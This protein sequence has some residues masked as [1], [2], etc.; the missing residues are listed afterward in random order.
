[1][2]AYRDAA[3]PQ[4]VEEMADQA[5]SLAAHVA[6]LALAHEALVPAREVVDPA[7]GDL[8]L[9][10]DEAGHVVRGEHAL[11]PVAEVVARD[12]LD[13]ERAADRAGA[14]RGAKVM[15]REAAHDAKAY[16]AVG[17]ELQGLA[18]AVDEGRHP[19]LVEEAARQETHIGDQVVAAVVVAL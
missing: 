10:S 2:S 11:A 1:I 7:P 12:Q 5:Q 14:G 9:R 18:A 17:E 4:R 8:L 19:L 16:A 3:R 13:L 15:I 6:R